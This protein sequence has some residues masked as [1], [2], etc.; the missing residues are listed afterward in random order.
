MLIQISRKFLK[1][2]DI[3]IRKLNKNSDF[4]N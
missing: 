1:H 3:L 4:L 2:I